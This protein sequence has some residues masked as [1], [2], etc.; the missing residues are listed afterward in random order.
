MSIKHRIR[1]LETVQ[2][3]TNS[4]PVFIACGPGEDPEEL[5]REQ[6]GTDGPPAGVTVFLVNTGV[7]RYQR[8][9]S[10]ECR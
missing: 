1:K 6:F 8:S 3:K 2:A 4:G 5:Q 7:P 9:R 10:N